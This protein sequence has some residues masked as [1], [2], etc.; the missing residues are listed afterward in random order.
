MEKTIQNSNYDGSEKARIE[1]AALRVIIIGTAIVFAV[2]FFVAYSSESYF[3]L[4]LLAVEAILSCAI[5][6]VATK[7]MS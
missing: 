4:K 2:G 3:L 7:F 6:Y 5:V 1:N